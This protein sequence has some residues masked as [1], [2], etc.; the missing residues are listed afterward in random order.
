MVSTNKFVS[1]VNSG[2]SSF[3]ESWHVY[4]IIDGLKWLVLLL[5]VLALKN[6]RSHWV[7]EFAC[8]YKTQH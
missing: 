7:E 5:P 6:S 2:S 8:K 1:T 3:K 4:E